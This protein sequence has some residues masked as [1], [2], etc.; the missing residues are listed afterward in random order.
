MAT[1]RRIAGGTHRFK[2]NGNWVSV[3]PASII[4][5]TADD[6]GNSIE[7]YEEVTEKETTGTLLEQAT[8]R[9]EILYRPKSIWFNEEKP[10]GT[11]LWQATPK[12]LRGLQRCLWAKT[13][14]ELDKSG[15][16]GELRRAKSILMAA[17]QDYRKACADDP[18]GRL[19]RLNPPEGD[20]LEKIAEAQA[21]VNLIEDEI[22]EIERRIAATEEP[23]EQK[24]E[25]QAARLR[26]KGRYRCN[27]DRKV[28]EC[29]GREVRQDEGD[30]PVFVD[31]GESVAEYLEQCKVHL[32]EA[33]KAIQAKRDAERAADKAAA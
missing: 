12:D 16:P 7:Q 17:W 23:L 8:R 28:I 1:F 13:T 24:K 30:K 20:Y 22:R 33:A 21:R 3:K 18:F 15:E 19:D 6:L 31:T 25:D 9:F 11:V 10:V 27:E 4:S 26:F 5:C 2:L 32:K 29:D 14:E